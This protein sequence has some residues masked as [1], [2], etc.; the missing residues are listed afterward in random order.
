MNAEMDV[1][2][3]ICW[4]LNSQNFADFL[5]TLILHHS[6]RFPGSQVAVWVQIRLVAGVLG[7]QEVAENDMV[8][9]NGARIISV[10]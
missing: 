5:C 2:I 8:I 3:F 10:E 1:T 4:S 9:R 7:A 6:H